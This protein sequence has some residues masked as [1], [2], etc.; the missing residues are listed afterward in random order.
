MTMAQLG[1]TQREPSMEEILA[2]IR[3][4]IEDSDLQKPEEATLAVRPA[5]DVR[6]SSLEFERAA[7]D[8]AVPRVA[9]VA[10]RDAAVDA[11]N[12]AEISPVALAEQTVVPAV[13]NDDQVIAG[14][15]F[16]QELAKTDFSEVTQSLAMRSEELPDLQK[17]SAI[18]PVD[19]RLGVSDEAVIDQLSED[20]FDLAEVASAVQEELSSDE[21]L[22]AI[23]PAAPAVTEDAAPVLATANNNEIGRPAIISDHTGRQV[24][25][26]FNELA[27]AFAARNR[28]SLEEVAEEMMR[29]MLQDW[30][31]NN[32]PNLVER[33]VREEIERVAR[34]SDA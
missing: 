23:A 33:L 6:P 9:T 16:E 32:L 34:G 1:N 26:S 15:E 24:T 14:L 20:D 13:A 28:R 31:D 4:I 25:A 19:W 7:G 8:R 18:D 21:T 29:P 22:S 27:E 11:A 30:L 5:N 10:N 2:S 17:T 3:R 12:E